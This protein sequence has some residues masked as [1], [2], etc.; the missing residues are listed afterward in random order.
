MGRRRYVCAWMLLVILILGWATTA[1]A[2][3]T[4]SLSGTVVDPQ[5]MAVRGAK[6]T[7]TSTTTGAERTTTV[8][9]NGH[10]SFLSLAPGTYKLTVDG[11]A[12][13]GLF[14]HASIKISAG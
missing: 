6:V 7:L 5:G 14:T 13:F 8:D 2:Q 11:G 12:N 3:N 1:S 9:D 4:A 10:Y